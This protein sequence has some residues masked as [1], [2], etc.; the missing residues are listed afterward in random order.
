MTSERT[1][2]VL[3][4]TALVIGLVVAAGLMVAAFAASF[5]SLFG[6]QCTAEEELTASMLSLASFGVFLLVPIA[7]AAVRRQ[8]RWLLAPFIEVALIATTFVLIDFF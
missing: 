7:V 8:T 3:S 6:E 1:K 4:A 2:N 5:C